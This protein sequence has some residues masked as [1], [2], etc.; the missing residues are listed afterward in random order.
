M[1]HRDQ[2]GFRSRAKQFERLILSGHEVTDPSD[3]L[4]LIPVLRTRLDV[5]YTFERNRNQL[6]VSAFPENLIY[7][8]A[9]SEGKRYALRP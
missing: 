8:A 7:A 2:V 6:F 5:V 1:L 3:K 4:K 9:L